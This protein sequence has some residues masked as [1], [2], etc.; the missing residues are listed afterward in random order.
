MVCGCQNKGCEIVVNM[1]KI[2]KHRKQY[3]QFYHPVRCHTTFDIIYFSGWQGR[4]EAQS[5]FLSLNADFGHCATV[6]SFDP[7]LLY[8]YR[9]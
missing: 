6:V 7:N 2:L 8:V 9:F 1:K 3:L 5:W 4:K